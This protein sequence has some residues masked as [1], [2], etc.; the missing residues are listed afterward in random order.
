MQ[1]NYF[2]INGF[3]LRKPPPPVQSCFLQ[4]LRDPAFFW[5]PNNTA[6]RG[7]G[8]EKNRSAMKFRKNAPQVC[9]FLN[10]FVQDCS[11]LR[12]LMVK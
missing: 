11:M 10:S 7:M 4:M 3:A 6:S 2:Q 8:G 5:W 9:N 1:Q 12:K